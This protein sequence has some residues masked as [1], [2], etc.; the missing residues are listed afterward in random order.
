[1][2]NMENTMNKP[3]EI[4][5][6]DK[7]TGRIEQ[8]SIL[9]MNRS[10]H[11]IGKISRYDNWNILLVANG[12]DEIVFDVHKYS[13]GRLCPVWDDL[14]DL[15]IVYVEGFGSFEISVDYVDNAETIKSVHGQSLEVEL[16]QINLHDFHV[17]DEEATDMK[18][19]EYSKDNYDSEG[20]YI[21]TTFYNPDDRK[22][23]LLHR[24]IASKAPHW[25]IGYV[26]PYIALGE[27]VQP[28]ESSRFQ[29]A[30]TVDGESIYD[31]LIGTVSEESNVIFTFDTSMDETTGR[32]ERTINCYSL[33]DC[34]NQ[35]DGTVMKDKDGNEVTGIG[36]DTFVFVS[37]D[38]LAN[39][40][41]I[42]SNKDNVK[43]CFR[44]EGGDDVIN[45]MVAAVNMGGNNY[46]YQF[47]DFQY[48]DMS[49]GLREKI[50]A[51]QKMME[52][53]DTQDM[54]YG[55]GKYIEGFFDTMPLLVE[56]EIEA[57]SLLNI[58]QDNKVDTGDADI[59]SYKLFPYW[60]VTT[61]ENGK[62]LE[63]FEYGNYSKSAKDALDMMGIYTKL[64]NAYDVLGYFES[65]MMPNTDKV[66]EPGD[67]ETQYHKVVDALTAKDFYVAVSSM[68][69]YKDNLF[70]GVTNNIEAY[71]KIFLDS[72]FDLEIIKDTTS[73]SYTEDK[74]TGKKTGTWKGK[75]RITQHTNE[76]NVYPVNMDSASL[77]EVKVNDDELEFARQKV[78]KKL[79]EGSLSGIDF[80]MEGIWG[81]ESLTDEEK[82]QKMRDYFNKYSLK[83]LESF[84]DGYNSCISV[85]MELGQTTTSDMTN[86][87]YNKYFERMSI[88]KEIKAARQTQVDE[89]NARIA[90]IQEE[91]KAF[92][93]GGEYNGK[94]YVP[95]D[96][97]A[98]LAN[99]DLYK[100]FCS[101]R[102][103]DTYTNNNYTSEGLSD[104]ECLKEAK[105]LIETATKEAK[106][107]CV[108][109]RTVSTSLNN[110]FAL[111]E[112]EPLYESFAMYNYIRVKT[113][114]EI[115]KLRLI[116]M[117]FMGESPEKI[118]VTFSEQ[119][120]SVDG[121][122]S[123][124]Q[125]V[126]KQARAMATSYPST[127]LQAR[128]GADARN[129]VA[130]IY[131][132]GLNASKAMLTNNDS[133]EVT[134]NSSGILCKR[135]DD[136]GFYGDKQLRITGNIMA[137]TDDNWKSVKMA[138]G[139]FPIYNPLTREYE[140]RYGVG[141]P[142]LVGEMIAGNNLDISNK[143]GSVHI[144]GDGITITNGVIKSH[145]YEKD[146][147]TGEEKG[148][149]IDLRDGSFSFA[150]GGFSYKEGN[151]V[152][153]DG[154][155]KSAN[156][157][158]DKSGSMIDL[159]NG[160]FD[161]AG[162][163]LAYKN[164]T[165]S[166]KGSVTADKLIATKIGKIANFNISEN[167]LYTDN[168][169][170]ENNTGIY[171]GNSGLRIGSGF[172]I[173]EYGNLTSAG[174]NISGSTITGADI[175]ANKFDAID[176]IKIRNLDGNRSVTL[177]VLTS[178][179]T[180]YLSVDKGV[181]VDGEFTSGGSIEVYEGIR[182]RRTD[183][184][185]NVASQSINAIYKDG[186]SHDVISVGENQLTTGIGWNGTSGSNSYNTVLQLKGKTVT[187]P[188]NGGITIQSDER[189]KNSFKPLD[190]FDATYMDI[191][192]CAFKYNN[193]SS[194][195][196]HFGAKAQDV[197]S[198][199]EKHGYTTQ[200]FG[201]FVQMSD[202]PKNDDY[203]GLEDPMGLIYTEFTMW[204]MHMVQKLYR[205]NGSLRTEIQTL[206][207]EHQT[208]QEEN[209]DLQKEVQ[210]MKERI[211]RLE[212]AISGVRI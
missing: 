192:P 45:A 15:K 154:V 172:K 175:T 60:N 118:E 41:S 207:K 155:I 23:S 83:R 39:E 204:N 157:I 84:Y 67:A 48:N 169:T 168:A 14:V 16:A 120:E 95:H 28:E 163:N 37:K 205:E 186:N 136:E 176:E 2:K 89:I 31:F 63:I 54:Y 111:P 20:D 19:T 27:D 72:R 151:L 127:T 99:D 116:G 76:K 91:Q 35:K 79:S 202:S 129:E 93:H 33:C 101:Y 8:P 185:G 117:E 106:K 211:K 165:L 70:A 85:L 158:P 109:Q 82:T 206:Q 64:C 113:E 138:I 177:E 18:Y 174:G 32:I 142:A 92:I 119:I 52:S 133:N 24:V 153:K 7:Y 36:E 190:E 47:A 126:I 65:S 11:I 141:A 3:C 148:S 75:I 181:F 66:K 139:E 137:F 108:L 130:D 17:N 209:R 194:G 159:T 87:I 145:D 170:F 26:T 212:R 135:M 128:Q 201:G 44:I 71:A 149:I 49:E 182:L 198:A 107:A 188:N 189:L 195:R 50:Q 62:E 78:Q 74:T 30:Y 55:N 131:D 208:L 6:L 102:R 112:F 61:T 104:S 187:A 184:S 110:L 100:E 171:L 140:M 183:S 197:K 46:I 180:N 146:E 152:L 80:D 115:L 132:N 13:D 147:G 5:K 125:S 58:C 166:V 203:C 98:Y 123:D 162:G 56:S 1:M 4:I 10:S 150:D 179:R 96:F 122:I 29:R 178:G 90:S 59:C 68:N 12:L 21:P 69:T 25:K 114:D 38:R 81:D 134:M 22:H 51:Y 57:A 160:E 94:T 200:D 196:Y 97:R 191:K 173:D 77:I 193:G 144:D 43:N 105:E 88:V 73:F 86:E 42:T 40:T 161:Y 164:N 53:K 9:L 199:F 167:E 103:E 156:Y 34:I 121:N 124:L 210:D 143:Q